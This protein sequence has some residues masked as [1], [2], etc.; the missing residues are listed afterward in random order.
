[1]SPSEVAITL[2]GIW[3]EVLDIEGITQ[4]D[5]FF[6]LGG[7]SLLAV[8]MVSRARRAGLH[9]AVKDLVDNPVLRDLVAAVS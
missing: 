7:D 8:T 9:I 1:M 5:H 4:D 6:E 3:E 2:S